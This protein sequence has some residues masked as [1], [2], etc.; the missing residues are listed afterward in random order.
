MG[1]GETLIFLP[2]GLGQMKKLKKSLFIEVYFV[3]EKKY[4]YGNIQ[5][6]V[7]MFLLKAEKLSKCKTW[8]VDCD[9]FTF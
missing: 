4:F 6:W 7:V 8:N 1:D 9:G 5:W 3:K 2:K